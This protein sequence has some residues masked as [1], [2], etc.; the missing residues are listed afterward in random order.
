MT[1]DDAAACSWAFPFHSGQSQGTWKLLEYLVSSWCFHLQNLGWIW[2]PEIC[3]RTTSRKPPFSVHRITDKADRI[4]GVKAGCPGVRLP[5]GRFPPQRPCLNTC[6]SP[7]RSIDVGEAAQSGATPRI[8]VIRSASA[9]PPRPRRVVSKDEVG[10]F[11]A[12]PA[13]LGAQEV[14]E[15]T[16]RQYPSRPG[17][18]RYRTQLGH[19][20]GQ[21]DSAHL[22]RS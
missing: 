2:T 10:I 7:V 13:G 17:R 3:R 22:A 14:V 21:A 20:P 4:Y 6:P 1:A 16:R 12:S 8:A 9:P 18:S 19:R 5:E 15:H 11:C